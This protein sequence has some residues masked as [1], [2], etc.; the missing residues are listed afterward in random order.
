MTTIEDFL[1]DASRSAPPAD[2]G[3]ALQALW[4]ARRGDWDRAHNTVQPHEGDPACDWVHAHLHR[5]EGDAENAD[6]WYQ[7]SGHPHAASP[8]ADEW[9]GIAT[10]LLAEGSPA[11]SG[12]GG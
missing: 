8:L 7:R 3:P 11:P 2:A 1:G 10:A 6:Y 5:Q 9:D 12:R 4:W